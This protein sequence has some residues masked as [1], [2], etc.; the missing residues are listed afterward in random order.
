MNGVARIL[1]AI[2]Q[3]DPQ[4]A[5][6]LLPL[7]YG[8]LRK[9]AGEKMAQEWR[10]GSSSLIKVFE[11]LE[12]DYP[13]ER[14]IRRG[15]A[16]GY[17]ELGR[18]QLET[19]SFKEAEKSFRES[20]R[21]YKALG[22]KFPDGPESPPNQ[23]QFSLR[24]VMIVTTTVAIVLALVRWNP[25]FG[26]PVSILIAGSTWTA[27]AVAPGRRR[28]AYYLAG[29]SM[30][31]IAMAVFLLPLFTI[32]H[33]PSWATDDWVSLLLLMKFCVSTTLCACL[34]R[35]HVR[36]RGWPPAIQSGLACVYVTAALLTPWAMVAS[37]VEIWIEGGRGE[38]L[39]LLEPVRLVFLLAVHL[40]AATLCL[41]LAG[42]VAVACVVLLRRIGPVI[43]D[44][45]E[46][47]DFLISTVR[48]LQ[49]ASNAPIHDHDLENRIPGNRVLLAQS[50]FRL[51]VAGELKWTPQQ[52]YREVVG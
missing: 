22:A 4:A 32:G 52:G 29:A 15:L 49:T 12:A 25:L 37:S 14:E 17:L 3:G 2:E 42:P 46:M 9:L 7:V 11:Q 40:I 23:F 33:P 31:P 8:E 44:P 34:L 19:G 16:E 47:E 50:L 18:V 24:T 30:G 35:R 41:P 6:K 43:T 5:E 10:S 20:V 26:G 21:L 13:D 45:A 38:A 36:R 39:L 51:M 28:L 1:S 48:F 27:L